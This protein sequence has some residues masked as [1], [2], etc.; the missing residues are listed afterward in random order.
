MQWTIGE[1]LQ[2]T[3]G[4]SALPPE[5][6]VS[7]IVT[8]SRAAA[9]GAV[10]VALKGERH[11]GHDFVGA[12]LSQGC[13]AALV[14]HVPPGVPR[15]RCLVVPD[16]L[17]ALGDVAGWTRQRQ[18]WLV[19][20]LTGSTGKTTTKEMIASICASARGADKVL[21]TK[22]NFNNL[23]G[24]PI[25]ILQAAGTEE[26]AVLEMGM[27]RFG[28]IRRLARIAKP[29]IALITNIGL[30]HAAG[31]GGTQAGVAR[32][33]GE[34]IEELAADATLVVNL[35]DE[36][37]CRLARGFTGRKIG[38]GAGG[39]VQAHWVRDLGA[40]G[41]V[42]ELSA[43]GARAR[44]RLRLVGTHNVS[45]ALAAAAVGLAMGFRVEVIAA[46]LEAVDVVD[47]RMV[48]VRLRNG[49]TVVDDTYNANPSSVEAA[50]KAL[51]RFP[52]RPLVVLGEMLELGGES[53]RA[54]QQVGERAAALDVR[55]LVLLGEET[56]A[57]AEAAVAAGLAPDRVHHCAN[58][59]EAAELVRRV[60]RSGDTVL[61]K[62][63]H[64]LHMEEVVRL[65]I[66][67]GN[68]S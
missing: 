41:V 14:E 11:D 43:A 9:P 33:K 10:F 35:E 37:V 30:A 18:G 42:F 22:G 31:V 63:S 36:W 24:L 59:A 21:K 47:G 2:A 60:W 39:E 52:G 40:D 54:H 55:L 65:L 45:N 16:T 62:G 68:S 48:V 12:A 49:V 64:S 5:R 3:G 6:V 15:E 29:N 23:V 28:E 17:T 66:H 20:G 32:A 38:Y 58:H 7:A 57:T 1:I 19:V 4:Q 26:T 53:R 8:D 61:V 27:N 50:L 13:E 44:V 25:T 56:K 34:L 67:S 51:R 46:G